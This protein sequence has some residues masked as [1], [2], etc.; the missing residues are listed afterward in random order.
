MRVA[1]Q[2]GAVHERARVALVGVAADE[3][4]VGLGGRREL[5]LHAGG[6]AR[7]AAAAQA[8][9]E[10]DVDDLLRGHLGEDLAQ[11]LVAVKGDVLLDV[12]RVDDAAVAQRDALLLLVEVYVVEGLDGVVLLD[13]LLVEQLLDDAALDEVLVHDAGD[14]LHGH[15]GVERALRIDDNDRA[16]LAQAE[17]AGADNLHFLVQTLLGKLLFKLLDDLSGVGGRTARTTA[18]HHMRANQI[19][20]MFL[21]FIA[22]AQPCAPMVYS[23]TGLPLTIWS[24][25]TRA[26]FSGVM[27]T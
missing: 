4:L 20:N 18:D 21:L 11:G 24:F 19:H 12:L 17:A 3:L 2:D 16:G 15:V 23:S 7:A 26:T 22:S 1:L 5:P 14:V 8:G 9:L 25:T 6:E 27:W 13:G 10:H